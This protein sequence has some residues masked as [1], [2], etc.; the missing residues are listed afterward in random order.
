VAKKLLMLV[1]DYVEDYEVMVPFQAL[2]MVGHKVD[3]VCPH[4]K[5][6]DSVRTAIHDFEGDQTYS[7]KRGHNFALNATFD[8]VVPEKYDA[9]VIPGGRAPEYLR[10]NPRVLEIVRHFAE[11]DKPIAAICH[12]AQV[13][14]AAGV[15]S[16]RSCSCYP[17]VGPEVTAAG[18]KYADIAID[19]AHTDGK[20][21]TAPAWPA[22]PAWLAQFLKVLG[23]KVE[24]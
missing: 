13:L 17:A 21:V 14:A 18:G 1:G 7:E 11:A 23:T 24:A 9:L 20:L 22:H 6:G 3:A 16:G 2:L 5:A 4:K 8:S 15:L 19:Q 12:G 10:L